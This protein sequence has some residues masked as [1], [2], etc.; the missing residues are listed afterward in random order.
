MGGGQKYFWAGEIRGERWTQTL[1]KVFLPHTG[2]L[3]SKIN[4]YEISNFQALLNYYGQWPE[5][6]QLFLHFFIMHSST[7]HEAHTN[8]K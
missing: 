2:F 6:L 5:S 1:A 4:T 8:R 7:R 3:Q